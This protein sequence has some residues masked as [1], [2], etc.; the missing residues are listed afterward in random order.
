MAAFSYFH[1]NFTTLLIPH[2]AKFSLN[3][4]KI[5]RNTELKF[6]KNFLE[7]QGKF[8]KQEFILINFFNESTILTLR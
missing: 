6:G 1:E 5:S 4:A 3:F 7:N 2:F 8:T